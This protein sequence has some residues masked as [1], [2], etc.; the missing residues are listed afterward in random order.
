MLGDIYANSVKGIN[1]TLFSED[2]VLRNITQ[3]QQIEGYKVSA[4][5]EHA[6]YI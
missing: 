1:L 5:Q 2:A 4:E 6:V 3:I